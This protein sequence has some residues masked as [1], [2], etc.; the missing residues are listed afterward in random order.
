MSSR[1]SAIVFGCLIAACGVSD[2]PDGGGG[3]GGGGG[4]GGGDGSGSGSGSGGGGGSTDTSG[5]ASFLHGMAVKYC[6]EAFTCKASFPTDAGVTF[7]QAFGASAMACYADADMYN[8]AAA[9]AAQITAGTITWNPADAMTCLAG[10]TFGTCAEFWMSGAN[11]PAACATALVGHVADGAACVVDY[12][13]SNASSYC[14]A[15]TKK[16]TVDTMMRRA[17]DPTL[18]VTRSSAVRY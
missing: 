13:C 5:V 18:G 3:G 4:S 7:E 2:K 9:V 17:P 6:D 1:L 16:C 10:I 14:D 12:E 8:N 15:T 11:Q